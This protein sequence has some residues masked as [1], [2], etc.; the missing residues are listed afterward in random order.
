LN[1]G[2]NGPPARESKIVGFVG[3]FLQ[4]PELPRYF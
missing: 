2:F 4:S 3:L 1:I